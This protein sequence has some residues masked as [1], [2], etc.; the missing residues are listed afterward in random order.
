MKLFGNK[1]SKH[2][3]APGRKSSRTTRSGFN[4]DTADLDIA[5][6]RAAYEAASADKN[7]ENIVKKHKKNRAKSVLLV[8][9]IIAAVVLALFAWYRSWAKLPE[10]EGGA[11]N[12]QESVEP[13]VTPS[14]TPGTDE[15][16]PTDTPEP[17]PD[18]G[19]VNQREGVYTFL[20]IGTDQVSGSTD[21]IMVA[22][23]DIIEHTIDVVSIP[24]DTL[25]S[26][27][28]GTKKVN[29][30]YAATG[31]DG[32][33]DG[34][35]DLLGY[36]IN[37]YAV[38]DIE[39][40]V[41][42]IDCI[43]GVDYNVPVDMYYDAPDQNLH[44]AI[45]K[46][47]QHLSGEEALKVVR[48][49]SGYATADIGRIG[50][51]QDFMMTVAKQLLKVGN[52]TKINE[53]AKIFEEYVDTNLTF[54]NIVRFGEEFLKVNPEDINFHIIP[55][56]YNGSIRMCSYC[57]INVDEWLAMINEH[58]NPLERDITRADVDILEWNGSTAVSTTGKTYGIESFTDY[59][60]YF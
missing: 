40:F 17:T 33:L 6:V 21:T 13:A 25:A 52:I 34:I 42:L 22:T 60:I 51:Q 59:S 48:F 16:E 12:V 19:A 26:V 50:T 5:A 20:A 23:F 36:K 43:G 57:L 28:W 15:P 7:T 10:I 56:N 58:F 49:R 31:L 27:S 55:A 3:P 45:P 47:Q 9:M 32:M 4:Q 1:H 29:T 35:S 46:G 24:R 39:A 38:V 18:V 30:I 54:G 2:A 41:K 8:V 14:V 44:I 53:F 11:H 37:C